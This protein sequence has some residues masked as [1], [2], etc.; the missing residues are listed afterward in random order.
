[1]A[2]TSE[3][4]ALTQKYLVPKLV[5]NIFD[6]NALFQRSRKKGWYETI[7]GGTQINMPLAYA[8]T[9]ASGRYS[10][11]ETLDTA[12]VQQ[13]TDAYFEWKEYYA[14]IPVTRIDELKN[15][16]KNAIINRV[17]AKVQLAEK[18]LKDTLGT[19][20]FNDG[21]TAK[22]LLG[23]RLVT[24]ATGT[25]GN[26]AKAT[27]SWWQGQVDSTTTV[28]TPAAL[29][30][31]IGD[32]TID[33]DKPSVIVTTQDILDD[34]WA[35][36][37]PQQRFSDSDTFKAGFSNLIFNGIPVIEDS[38]CPSGYVFAINESYLHLYAHKDENF[39]FAPFR[40]PT[41]QNVKVAQ[42]FWTGALACDNCRMQGVMTSIA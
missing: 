23:L 25:Y 1:M 36:L 42:I 40:Q 34:L 30:A 21:S 16:G 11:S 38:H 20:L 8:T 6:S 27:Y 29:Q 22:A 9:S 13:I 24:A 39:R 31:L 5:D 28:M 37:Q 3:I 12:D 35:A 10:G 41:N 33:S 18:T 7:D 26:I 32:C 17:K 15:S 4:S 19:D 14:S 2:L